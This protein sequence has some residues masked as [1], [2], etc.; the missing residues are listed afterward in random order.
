MQKF[1][2]LH[3]FDQARL[4]CSNMHAIPLMHTSLQHLT[5]AWHICHISA[6]FCM[7]SV[8]MRL[9]LLACAVRHLLMFGQNDRV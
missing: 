5:V 9:L 6:D 4:I 3:A 1:Q 8:D 7:Y 2:V